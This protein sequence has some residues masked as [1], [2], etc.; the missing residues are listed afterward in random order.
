VRHKEA[1]K[2]KRNRR[3]FFILDISFF[4]EKKFFD[5]L[6]EKRNKVVN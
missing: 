5:I 4:I 1:L 6:E 3:K 2:N